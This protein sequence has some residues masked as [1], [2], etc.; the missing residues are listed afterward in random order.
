MPALGTMPPVQVDQ[1]DLARFGARWHANGRSLSRTPPESSSELGRL[2]DEAVGR[3]LAGFLGGIPIARPKASALTPSPANCVEVGP[4]TIV[5]GVRPQRYDV[6]YRPDGPRFAFDSK[7]LNDTESVSKNF[8][9]MVNDLATE[10]TTVHTRFP[11]ALVAF[12]FIVPRPCLAERSRK[13]AAAL[14]TLDRLAQRNHFDDPDHLA[15]AIAV[16]VWDPDTGSIDAEIPSS[17]SR[18]RL[19]Q[20]SPTVER[21]YVARYEG[22]PPHQRAGLTELDVQLTGESEDDQPAEFEDEEEE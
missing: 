20:F 13:A 9:N 3:S 1:A 10:A 22:L 15:E 21:I 11:Y 14:D 5:G 12:M 4:V 17:E 8:L 6:G 19:E 7:T 16:V 2:F 18:L